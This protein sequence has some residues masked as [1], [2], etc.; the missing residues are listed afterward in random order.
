[1][2]VH[3]SSNPVRR[4]YYALEELCRRPAVYGKRSVIILLSTQRKQSATLACGCGAQYIHSMNILSRDCKDPVR[5]PHTWAGRRSAAPSAV[6]GAERPHGRRSSRLLS[7][8]CCM[9]LSSRRAQPPRVVAQDLPNGI[10]LGDCLEAPEVAGPGFSIFGQRTDGW[11]R[12][13]AP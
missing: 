13:C 6:D 1:V 5:R 3:V 9:S 11:Q 8:N 12:T 7:A 2:I 10:A 4:E